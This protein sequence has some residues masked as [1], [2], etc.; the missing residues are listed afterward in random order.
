LWGKRKKVKPT[1]SNGSGKDFGSPQK[2]KGGRSW[3]RSS[4]GQ[5]RQKGQQGKN[6][7]QKRKKK[8]GQYTRI[9][10]KNIKR[11]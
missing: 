3:T 11:Q 1:S 7:E 10:I 4:G 6:L 2:M 5:Q 9:D 8:Q